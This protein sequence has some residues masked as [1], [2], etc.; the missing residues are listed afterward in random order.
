M[1][2]E[3]TDSGVR[4]TRVQSLALL[5]VFPMTLASLVEVPLFISVFLSVKWEMKIVP[6]GKMVELHST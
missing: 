4:T 5:F 6:L 1:V 2:M 3:G